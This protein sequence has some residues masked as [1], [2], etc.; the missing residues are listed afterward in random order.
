MDVKHIYYHDRHVYAIY[1][2]RNDTLY[3]NLAFCGRCKLYIL[4]LK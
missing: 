1:Y 4:N 2:R 3:I